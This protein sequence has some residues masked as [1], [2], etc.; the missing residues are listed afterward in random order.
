MSIELFSLIFVSAIGVIL[1]GLNIFLWMKM[2]RMERFFQSEAG[3]E[4]NKILLKRLSL[5][6][7]RL[8]KDIQELYEISSR[9][10]KVAKKGICKIGVNRFNTFGEQGGNQSFAIALLDFKDNGI[11]LSTLQTTKG[12]RMFIRFIKEGSVEGAD[13]ITEEKKAL[14]RAQQVIFN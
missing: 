5:E 7:K 1:F 4:N 9:I 14:A 8:D 13:L 12:A 2:N 10:S 6:S 3:D 11:I